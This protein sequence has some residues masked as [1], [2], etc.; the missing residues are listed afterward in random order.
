VEC[1]ELGGI[2]I[3][4]FRGIRCLVSTR[5]ERVMSGSIMAQFDKR[6]CLPTNRINSQILL[7]RCEGRVDVGVAEDLLG[8]IRED[9]ESHSMTN[10]CCKA[11]KVST[12]FV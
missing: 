6:G 7:S 8:L 2:G 12:G 11:N 10:M 3:L 5:V 4:F 9:L 1:G